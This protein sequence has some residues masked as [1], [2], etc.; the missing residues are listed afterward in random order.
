MTAKITMNRPGSNGLGVNIM[1]LL[2]QKD[3]FI[4]KTM[5]TGRCTSHGSVAVLG[6]I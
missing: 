4:V 2:D 1:T 3:V 6:Y 5:R